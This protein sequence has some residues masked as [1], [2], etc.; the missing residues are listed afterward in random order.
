MSEYENDLVEVPARV[1]TMQEYYQRTLLMTVATVVEKE[2]E[3][4][5][6]EIVP[7]VTDK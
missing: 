4:I 3:V 7:P 1:F 6:V 2:A 5:P